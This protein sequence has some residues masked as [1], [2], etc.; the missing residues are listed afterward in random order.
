MGAINRAW[1]IVMG[2]EDN[3][4]ASAA[5]VQVCVVASHQV[6]ASVIIKS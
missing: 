3:Y 4:D 2:T 5:R 1:Q 6:N